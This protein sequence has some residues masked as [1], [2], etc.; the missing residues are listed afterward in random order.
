MR[1]ERR[2]IY[3]GLTMLWNVAFSFRF[4]FEGNEEEKLKVKRLHVPG[5]MF[6]K[7]FRGQ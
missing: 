3:A 7:A 4:H 2:E 5:H 6:K 1:N